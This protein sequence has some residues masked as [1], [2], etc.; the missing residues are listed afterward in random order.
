MLITASQKFSEKVSMDLVTIEHF[1][2]ILKYAIILP[3]AL[4]PYTCF[5]PR[6]LLKSAD[7]EDS[8]SMNLF[9]INILDN[10]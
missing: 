9:A 3:T 7:A 2:Y 8:Y 6:K 5:R 10:K 1:H 4:S